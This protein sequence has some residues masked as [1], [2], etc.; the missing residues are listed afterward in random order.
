MD[1]NWPLPQKI[2]QSNS[3]TSRAGAC[4]TRCA[5]IT[6]RRFPVFVLQPEWESG[7]SRGSGVTTLKLWDVNS[8]RGYRY[9]LK[10]NTHPVYSVAFAP[11]G[12]RIASVK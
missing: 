10:G 4:F 1:A 9:T 3:G 8:G 7:F 11:N 5:D 12:K 6:Y 2:V